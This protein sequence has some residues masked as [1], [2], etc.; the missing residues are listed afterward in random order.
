MK[1]AIGYLRVDTEGTGLQHTGTDGRRVSFA[2]QHAT[3]RAAGY[4]GVDSQE[5]GRT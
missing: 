5:S 1:D 3:S 2:L 4:A